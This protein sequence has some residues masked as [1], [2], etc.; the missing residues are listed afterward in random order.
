[1]AGAGAAAA[2]AMLAVGGMFDLIEAAI[3]SIPGEYK[4]GP[5]FRPWPGWTKGYMFA[6]PIWFGFVFAVG[7]AVVTRL[8]PASGWLTAGCR[9]AVYGGLLFLLGSLPVFALVYAS[10]L[11]SPE[12]VAVSWAGR[13]LAQYVV[14]G[15]CVG[16]VTRLA[17]VVRARCIR[18][19]CN[20]EC[21]APSR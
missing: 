21:Q 13:N 16:M 20:D 15:V 7:F 9:G 2:V 5:G 14:A 11:V 12:L 18:C 19:R 1:V 17:E 6:H 8:R 4:A 10:F 3:P